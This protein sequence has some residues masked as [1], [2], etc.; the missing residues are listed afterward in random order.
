MSSKNG[1][2]QF[3]KTTV[4]GGLLFLVPVVILIMIVTKAAG[5]MMMVA[6]P[7]AAW[8]P[9]DSIG[10]VAVANLIAALAV[11]VVCFIAGLVARGT[12]LRTIVENLESKVL[13]K[14]PGYMIVKSI[15]IGLQGE[16]AQGLVPVLATFGQTD[17][18]GLEI[19]RLDDGRVVVM[20]PN[21]PN[22]WSG[23]VS[24]IAPEAVRRLDLPLAAYK[25]NIE[26]LGQGTTELLRIDRDSPPSE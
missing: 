5:L 13:A 10:G 1:G 15:L 11:V 7:M 22:P 24:V 12:V 25:E 6:Q 2:V 20:I 16:D 14:V 9:V 4:I 18:I 21:A 19:E 26:Q 17:R 3:F 23:E 8:L